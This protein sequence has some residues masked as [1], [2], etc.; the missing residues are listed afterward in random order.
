MLQY[1]VVYCAGIFASFAI[2]VTANVAA[3]STQNT[4]YG[5]AAFISYVVTVISGRFLSKAYRELW[6]S[7]GVK[8]FDR[9]SSYTWYGAVLLIILVGVILLIVANV[10]ALWGF[11]KLKNLQ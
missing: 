3:P 10:H 7:S 11:K 9:A 1:L 6:N 5:A 4:H 2:G 8:D